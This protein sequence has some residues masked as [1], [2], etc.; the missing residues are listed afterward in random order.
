[1]FYTY[2]VTV[3]FGIDS[4]KNLGTLSISRF[5]Q[6]MRNGPVPEPRQVEFAVHP[7]TI[8]GK[9]KKHLKK[10]FNQIIKQNGKNNN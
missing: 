3:L 7:G 9:L 8:P 1:M 2:S 4:I 6:S 5:T 10:K